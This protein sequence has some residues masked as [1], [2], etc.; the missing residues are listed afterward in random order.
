MILLKFQEQVI[1]PKMFVERV[2][3][4]RQDSGRQA[5][6]L[7]LYEEE[8]SVWDLPGLRLP[9]KQGGQV[10]PFRVE[11][12]GIYTFPAE[13]DPRGPWVWGEWSAARV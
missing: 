8:A 7:P 5:G 13:V 11:R 12:E 1:K 3:S 9:G 6:S 10:P 4:E 2:P